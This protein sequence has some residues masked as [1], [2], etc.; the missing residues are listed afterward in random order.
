MNTDQLVQDLEEFSRLDK[1]G[2]SQKEKIMSALHVVQAYQAIQLGKDTSTQNIV[3]RSIT[4]IKEQKNSARSDTEF[5]KGYRE[6][7][8]KAVSIL[9]EEIE[10]GGHIRED[11]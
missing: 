8:S 3:Q 9:E 2:H 7:L 10:N 4:R 5:V 11:K 6:G 1:L